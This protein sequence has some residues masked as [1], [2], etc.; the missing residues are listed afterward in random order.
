MR[1][2]AVEMIASHRGFRGLYILEQT[3]GLLRGAVGTA[4]DTVTTVGMDLPSRRHRQHQ[5]EF[6]HC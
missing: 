6:G 2:Q 5:L 1:D 4:P 3:G